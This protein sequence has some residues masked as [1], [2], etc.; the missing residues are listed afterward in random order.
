MGLILRGLAASATQLILLY[1]LLIVPAGLIAGEWLWPRGIQFL[2]TYAVL[3]GASTVIMALIAPQSLE[4]RLRRPSSAEQP[5]ADK[6]ATTGVLAALALSV[7]FVPLDVFGWHVLGAPSAR[8]ASFAGWVAVA[9]Y[10][11]CLWVIYVNAF[12]IPIVEDQSKVGQ[13]LVSS[14]PYVLV[15]HPMYLSFLLMQA[16]T[17]VWLGSVA[18]LFMLL[19]TFAALIPRVFIEERMLIDTLPGYNAYRAS[20]RPR[21]LPFVW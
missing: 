11:L 2:A 15:R 12:A 21:I 6:L 9:G 20:T 19:V 7:V 5:V 13:I 18:S 16:G 17:G 14:G 3:L 1:V 10:A 4:A 8:V